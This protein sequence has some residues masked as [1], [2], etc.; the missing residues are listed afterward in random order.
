[1]K[2]VA[3]IIVFSFLGTVATSQTKAKVDSVLAEMQPG[4]ELTENILD[5]LLKMKIITDKNKVSFALSYYKMEV[6]NKKIEDDV[7]EKFRAK[8][9]KRE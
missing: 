1:M 4:N 7:F 3:L 5:D 9:I 8:Y 6:N 2:T